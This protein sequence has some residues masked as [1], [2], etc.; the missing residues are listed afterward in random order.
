MKHIL[1][2]AAIICFNQLSA[3][4]LPFKWAEHIGGTFDDKANSVAIDAAGDIYVA[5]YFSDTVDFDPGTGVLTFITD[6]DY[7]DIFITKFD[8]AGHLIWAKQIHG[9]GDD[10]ALSIAADSYGNIYCTG[11]FHSKVDFDPDSGIYNLTAKGN[12]DIFIL[13]LDTAGHFKWAED[14]GGSSG[15]DSGYFITTDVQGN[16]LITGD[17]NDKCDFDPSATAYFLNSVNKS[18]DIFIE[19]LDSAGSFLWVATCGSALSD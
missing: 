18:Q 6:W 2:F 10:A 5:G 12:L 8:P 15:W 1:L 7:T 3:Q 9:P 13:K 14:I 17:F 16:I 4:Q 19:K 11:Y